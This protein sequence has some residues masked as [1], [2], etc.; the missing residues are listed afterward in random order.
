MKLPIRKEYFDA[1]KE[2]NK[3]FEYRDAHI[4]FVC[5]ETGRALRKKV[6]G[7]CFTSFDMLP[8]WLKESGMFEDDILIKFELGEDTNIPNR[9]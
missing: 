6:T 4:T 1:I 8:V 5:E 3:H 7:V 2:G 9:K